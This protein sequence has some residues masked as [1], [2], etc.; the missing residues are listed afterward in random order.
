MKT[1]RQFREDTSE[2]KFKPPAG[3]VEAAKKAIK[4]KEEHGDDEVTAMTKTGWT[5]ARQLANGDELSYDI[6]KRMSNFNRHRKNSKI[7]PKFK[8]EPWKDRGYVAWLG[9][10]GDA[11]VDWAMKVVDE[12]ESKTDG[13]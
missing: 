2:S 4:W 11:G 8:N 3:A 13:R 12:M 10:G 7:D 1:F 5:R 9:W 6:V